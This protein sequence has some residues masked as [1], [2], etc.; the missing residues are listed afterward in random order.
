[1]KKI[2]TIIVALVLCCS[3]CFSLTA[4]GSK[5][6]VKL[7]QVDLSSEEYAF[8]VKKNDDALLNSVN[9]FLAEEKTAIDAIFAKYMADDAPLNTFGRNDIQTVP[10]G[11]ENE[12]V[13]ATN[14]DF[15]PFEYMNG[16]KIAGIDMEIAQLLADYL[17]KTLVIVHMDFEA[18]VTSVQELDTYD[19][20]M[21]GLTITPDRAELIDFSDAYFGATQSIIVMEDDTTFDGLT[22]AEQVEEKLSTLT[23]AAA[24]CGGQKGTTSQFYVIGSEDFGFA[25]FSNLTFGQYTSAALAIQD[26]ANDRI[27]FV[28]VDKTTA[29]AL[30]NNYNN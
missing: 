6:K 5:A 13:V 27:S 29:T 24:K 2:L 9:Q 20:G 28:V 11:S 22:T 25:G 15:A 30:V 16:N 12:L 17:N 8:A 23:G 26:M 3:L 7:I 10:S 4:C 18:V 14:L 21:A 1:M 19:I